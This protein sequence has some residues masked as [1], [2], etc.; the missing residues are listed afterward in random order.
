M[1]EKTRKAPR[2]AGKTSPRGLTEGKGLEVGGSA[3]KSCYLQLLARSYRPVSLPNPTGQAYQKCQDARLSNGKE[4]RG[5]RSG[6]LHRF[7]CFM[8]S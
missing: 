7:L 2:M 6:W 8:R 5:W 3:L 1:T 4:K